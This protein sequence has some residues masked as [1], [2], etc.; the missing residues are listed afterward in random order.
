MSGS[1]DCKP[2]YMARPSCTPDRKLGA[3]RPANAE[4]SPTCVD[5]SGQIPRKRP[6]SEHLDAKTED[7]RVRPRKDKPSS[8]R[9]HAICDSGA[10]TSLGSLR[11]ISDPQG[12][13]GGLFGAAFV[14]AF[15]LPGLAGPEAATSVRT[16]GGKDE[17]AADSADLDGAEKAARLNGPPPATPHAA[18]K[19]FT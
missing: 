15:V 19:P 11:A 12:H 18:H 7:R 2:A 6:A 9:A 14:N 8:G 3:V 1:L 10:Q 17:E 5:M 4:I 13:I 16:A